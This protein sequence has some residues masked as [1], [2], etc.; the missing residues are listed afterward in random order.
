MKTF[1]QSLLAAL[2]AG[3]A[4]SSAQTLASGN[5]K[6]VGWTAAAGALVGLAGL[7]TKSPLS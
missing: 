5:T 4:T 7:L 6:G 2:I 3:A 1:W